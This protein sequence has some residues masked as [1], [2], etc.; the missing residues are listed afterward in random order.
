MIPAKGTILRCLSR[1]LSSLRQGSWLSPTMVRRIGGGLFAAELT[2]FAVLALA[3]YNVFGPMPEPV[4][5][6]FISFYAAGRLANDGM[7]ELAY[8]SAMHSM[9]EQAIFGDTGLRY[10]HF[11]YPPVFLPIC[12]ALAAIDYLPSQVAFIFLTAA[13]YFCALRVVLGGGRRILLFFTFP[14][15]FF[16]AALGQNSFLTAALIGIA[17]WF[18]DR[19]PFFAGIIWGL[20]CFKPHFLL[21]TP[22][23]LVAGGRWRALAGLTLSMMSMIALSLFLYGTKC[24]AAYIPVALH[25]PA[26]FESGEIPPSGMVSVFAA[27][28]LLGASPL[29]SYAVQG[30]G[31]AIAGALVVVVWRRSTRSAL[32]AAVLVAASGLAVPVILFYDLLP[33]SI[34]IA[35]MARD[36][37]TTGVRSWEKTAM[38]LVWALSGLVLPFAEWLGVPVGPIPAVLVLAM[39]ANRAIAGP[40]STAKA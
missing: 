39:A 10:H 11:L 13:A 3:T 22:V 18:I 40:V 24:W 2:L 30:V 35:W 31:A 19:R 8:D 9:T 4:S 33:L 28:R 20:Q 27:A 26:V 32:R 34:A 36:I 21:M 29:V 7:P 23:A 38:T 12:Q 14:P 37:S 5:T 16:A 6:D 25:A 15:L 1:S 17:T